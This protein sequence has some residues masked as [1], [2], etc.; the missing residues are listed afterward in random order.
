MYWFWLLTGMKCVFEEL[1]NMQKDRRI[2][3]LTASS[4][5]LPRQAGFL[6]I[7]YSAEGADYQSQCSCMPTDLMGWES[8]GQFVMCIHGHA[9]RSPQR[10]SREDMTVFSASAGLKSDGEREREACLFR[11]LSIALSH[12]LQ[13]SEHGWMTH[14]QCCPH[15]V[16]SKRLTLLPRSHWGKM[17]HE[18]SDL[19]HDYLLR[20]KRR[21]AL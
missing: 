16:H 9:N 3:I 6:F 1:V 17:V 4:F 14:G 5:F 10:R 21:H 11:T 15:Y 7:R 13:M 19:P 12:S 18:W 2:V 20:L 8:V